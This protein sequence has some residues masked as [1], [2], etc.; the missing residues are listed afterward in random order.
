MR[1]F[2]RLPGRRGPLVLD[3]EK[4]GIRTES[5]DGLAAEGALSRVAVIAHWAP[6]SRLSRSVSELT[7]S[8][9]DHDYQ[10]VVASSAEGEAPLEWSGEQPA[11]VTVLRRP[12]VGYD[13][14]SWATALDRYPAIASAGQVLLM[15]DSLAGPFGPIDDLLLDF[16]GSG[17]DVWGMTDT[18]QFGHHLQ[19]Y[20]LG[21]KRGCLGERPLAA[22]WSDIRVE[23]SRDDVIWRYEIGLSRL[24]HRERFSVDAAIRYRKVVR[25]GENPTIIGWRRLLDM[26]FP[27]VKRQLLRQPEVAPDGSMVREEVRRKFGVEVDQWL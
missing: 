15:N 22:F 19:S 20:C 5:E 7:R 8:L 6:D 23:K 17:A 21:F 24:L 2:V 25:D 10:V 1:R 27:F 26:G 13:F 14:G 11:N 4:S 16:D 12:N 9:I 18:S 3:I